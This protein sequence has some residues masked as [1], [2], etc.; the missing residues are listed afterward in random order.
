MTKKIFEIRLNLSLTQ[1][2]QTLTFCDSIAT[3]ITNFRPSSIISIEHLRKYTIYM[4]FLIN[5][6]WTISKYI[7]LPLRLYDMYVREPEHNIVVKNPNFQSQYVNQ[8]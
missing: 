3:K 5:S 4:V 7:P 8:F 6:F 2:E 1:F